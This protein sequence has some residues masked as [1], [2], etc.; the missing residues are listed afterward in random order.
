MRLRRSI[1]VDEP[2]EFRVDR[3]FLFVILYKPINIPLF[4]GSVRDLEAVI[5]KDEL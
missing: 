1:D 4:V 5:E 3:P 2:E